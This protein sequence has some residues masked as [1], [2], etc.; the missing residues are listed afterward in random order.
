[1]NTGRERRKES[2][3]TNYY[4]HYDC[5]T[6]CG[7]AREVRHIGKASAG[8]TFTFRGYRDVSPPILSE[9]DWRRELSG[10]NVIIRDEYGEEAT[11]SEFWGMVEQKRKAVHNHASEYPAENTLLDVEGNGFIC[12][13]FS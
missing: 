11:V 1:M 8:W 4:A 10:E 3:G 2:M 7:R 9:K 12:G 6:E 5:C 13:E